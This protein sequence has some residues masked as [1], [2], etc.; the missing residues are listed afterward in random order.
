MFT[1][2][3]SYYC[4]KL[5]LQDIALCRLKQ[6]VKIKKILYCHIYH[7]RKVVKVCELVE[8]DGEMCQSSETG[9]FFNF[10]Q[11]VVVKVNHLQ[12]QYVSDRL[13]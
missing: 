13:L 4:P 7:V 8:A 5:C 11:T 6:T 12:V 1:I 2:L 9:N 10:T 3:T